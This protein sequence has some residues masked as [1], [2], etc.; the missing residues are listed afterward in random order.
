L[1][2][3]ICMSS[4]RNTILKQSKVEGRSCELEG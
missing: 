3:S 1:M 4:I 2:V